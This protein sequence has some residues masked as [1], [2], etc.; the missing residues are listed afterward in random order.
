MQGTVKH[1][2]N[3]GLNTFGHVRHS[4]NCLNMSLNMWLNMVSTR[5]GC[6]SCK[7]LFKHVFKHG[8][9]HIQHVRHSQNCLNMC[10]NMGLNTFGTCGSQATV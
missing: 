1:V 5:S 6:V 8:F 2:L 3:M 7:E 4:Q 9:N 10:L